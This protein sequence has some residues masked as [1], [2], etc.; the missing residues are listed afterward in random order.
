MR[1]KRCINGDG[2]TIAYRI[3]CP[4]CEGFHVIYVGHS[5]PNAN[6]QFNGDFERPT[7]SPSLLVNKDFSHPGVPRCHSFIRDGRIQF[8]NDSTHELAGKT[9]DLPEVE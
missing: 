2:E 4:G 7:F 8:L 1:A 3:D 6:W 5:N 9:V